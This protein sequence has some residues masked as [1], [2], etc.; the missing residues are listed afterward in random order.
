MKSAIAL[1]LILAVESFSQDTY[2]C[3]DG[4]YVYQRGEE[5]HCYLLDNEYVTHETAGMIC[6]MEFKG[7]KGWVAEVLNPE[8]NNFLKNVLYEDEIDPNQGNQWWLGAYTKE[9]DHDDH[10]PGMWKWPHYNVTAS[11]FDWADGEPNNMHNDE[12]CLTFYEYRNPDKPQYRDFLW[13]DNECF[14]L[15]R[16]I[17]EGPCLDC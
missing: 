9:K 13:N 11:W 17:C 12:N 2:H 10:H 6:K 7:Y 3:P 1:L 5:V 15:A 8:V 4:W 14:G 16:T